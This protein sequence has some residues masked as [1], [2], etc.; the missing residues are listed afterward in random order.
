M[1]RCGAEMHVEI[2]KRVFIEPWQQ[3]IKEFCDSKGTIRSS[4]F[5]LYHFNILTIYLT[6]NDRIPRTFALFDFQS[7]TSS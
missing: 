6:S 4:K 1:R 3:S 2:A 7:Q 5:D